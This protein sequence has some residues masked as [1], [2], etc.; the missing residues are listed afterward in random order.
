MDKKWLLFLFEKMF[1][2]G[3]LESFFKVS[4]KID[5]ADTVKGNQAVM[6]KSLQI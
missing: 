3:K 2:T 6:I 5:R 4:M 1:V